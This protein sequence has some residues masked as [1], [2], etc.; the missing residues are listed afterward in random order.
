METLHIY[1]RVSSASQ[2]E[3][4]TSLDNQRYLGVKK[5]EELGFSY[6]VWNEGGQSS[7]HDDLDNRPKLVE[8]LSEIEDGKVKNLFVYNTDRLSRNQKTWGM[9]RYKLL[10]NEVT[11]HTVSGKI[12]LKNPMDDLLL[13][14][15][16]EIS[17]YDNKIRTERV[18][19]GRFQKVKD[20]NW[21]GG[22]P[23][24]GYRLEDKKLVIEKSESKWVKKIFQWY[25]EGKSTMEIKERLDTSGV[26]TRHKKGTWSIGSIQAILKNTTYVGYS[27]YTDKFIGETIK[28][29]S[30]PIIEDGIWNSVRQKVGRSRSV[31][32]R[33][34][35]TKK[36][37]L[38]RDLMVCDHCGT[39]LSGRIDERIG[40][41]V[42]YCPH[43]ERAW[44]K[45]K[46][47]KSE[48]WKR[49]V[50][51]A[52]TKSLN[53][54]RTDKF[55][56]DT[57]MKTVEQSHT[58]KEKYRK[59]L[60]NQVVENR[61]KK[62]EYIDKVKGKL[63][64]LNRNLEKLDVTIAN[65]ESDVLLDRVNGNPQIIRSNLLDERSKILGQLESTTE[66][67]ESQV[68]QDSWVDWLSSFKLDV[69]KK[70]DLSD[71]DKKLYLT[72]LIDEIKVRY[73]K[74]S[75]KHSLSIGF[76]LPIVGD[77]IKYNDDTDHRKGWK[78]REGKSKVIL[79]EKLTNVG[80]PKK[81]S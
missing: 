72:N 33:A 63:K 6:Q 35:R 40:V 17:Q 22:P 55:V 79:K 58:L 19:Q 10:E 49:G 50:G 75:N 7:H 52:M 34:N 56:L 48:R 26:L 47:P 18:R 43:K 20:G 78:I 28:S 2:E 13:G 59:D 11:L 23:P 64:R 61:G 74:D 36:F 41:R 3:D 5:S 53:I 8:L 70:S 51:C 31:R 80:R 81:K 12:E 60:I 29:F 54:P 45:G 15:L 16:S 66:D 77:Q 73:D 44:V 37:Y 32:Q 27:T 14:I 25:S 42:Y 62:S 9:I 38:L 30:P 71:E 68:I 67:Y 39:H 76:K 1:T 69:I 65:F 4:G 46:K 24:F 57:V 21:R